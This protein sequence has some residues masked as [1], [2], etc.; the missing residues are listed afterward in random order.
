[1]EKKPTEQ[2]FFDFCEEVL[3]LCLFLVY[4]PYPVDLISCNIYM[5]K[6]HFSQTGQNVNYVLKCFLPS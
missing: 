6:N 3:L 2:S 4:K 5:P 1:M